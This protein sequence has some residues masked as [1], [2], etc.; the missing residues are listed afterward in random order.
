MGVGRVGGVVV[1]GRA[2]GAKGVSRAGGVV[3]RGRVEAPANFEKNDTSGLWTDL[4]FPMR[5]DIEKARGPGPQCPGVSML[6]TT[7]WEPGHCGPGPGPGT[8]YTV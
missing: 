1:P 5:I 8:V 6:T 3:G 4:D 2:G 7:I